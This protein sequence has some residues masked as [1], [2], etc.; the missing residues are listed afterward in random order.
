MSI[1]TLISHISATSVLVPIIL[2]GIQW[3]RLS[4]ELS[5]LRWILIASFLAD[6]LSLILIKNSISP[7]PLGNA[8][9]L[10][11]FSLLIYMF[12][13]SKKKKFILATIYSIYLIFYIINLVFFQSFFE[14]N[15]HSI[16]VSSL[17]LMF[18]STHYLYKLLNELPIVY[19]D[20]LPMLWV[21]FAVLFYYSGT[22][23]LFLANN[24]LLKVFED[25]YALLWTLHNLLNVTKNLLFAVALWQS[26]RAMK[27]STLS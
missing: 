12:S 19:I 9:L 10:I 22:F 21:A 13:H 7:T 3:K 11:Q 26:Y 18:I 8:Y 14:F 16:V 5:L 20:K 24:Y 1:T 4:G 23:F 2:A 15:T 17:I 27:S 6:V 25:D